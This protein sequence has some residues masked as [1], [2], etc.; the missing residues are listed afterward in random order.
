M[1]RRFVVF[2]AL[3]LCVAVWV[4]DAE[5]AGAWRSEVQTQGVGGAYFL[6]EPGEFW[7]EVEKQDLNR[8]GRETHLRAILFGPEREV[9]AEEFIPD[10]G[11]EKGAGPVQRVRLSTDVTRKGVYGL[12]ITVTEDR[13]GEEFVCGIRTNCPKYLIETS[14]G[15]RDAP[16]EEPTVLASPG[17]SGEICF[18]PRRG[19]FAIE[20]TGLGDATEV[21][22]LTDSEGGVIA[23]IPVVDGAASHTVTESDTRERIPWRLQF[24]SFQGTVQIDGLTRWAQDDDFENLSLWSP[25]AESWFPFSENRW[26]LTPYHRTVYGESGIAR[27]LEFTV[28]NNGLKPQ[29]VS[30]NVEMADGQAMDV[31]VSEKD[32]RLEPKES[33]GVR[34]EFQVPNAP[35]EFHL[36]ATAEDSSFSTYST[37]QVR[38]G[39]APASE[40][41][42]MPLVLRPYAHENAQFGYL[43]EYP[44][45]N[46]PYFDMKNRPAISSDSGVFVLR[47][48]VWKETTQATTAGGEAAPIRPL[49]SKVAFD[50][51]NGYYLIASQGGR[52]TYLHSDDG[53][54][55]FAAYAIPGSGGFDIEQFSGHNQPAG[56]PPFV[57]VTLTERDP[58][59]FWRRVNDLDLF[60]PSKSEDGT[61]V[62]GDPIRVSRLCIGLSAHSGIPSTIV[63]RDDKVH[64]VWAE[65]TE[66]EKDVPGVPT[67]VA[68]YD[69]VAQALSDPVLVGYGPPANDV[70]NTP[71]ITMDSE[72][73]L[74]VLVGTHGR[75]FRYARSLVPNDASGGFTEAEDLGE[76]L[77]QTYIGLVCDKEDTLHAVFRL[78][79][80]DTTY[81]PASSYATLSYMR[82]EKGKPWSAPEPLIIAAF[83]EY[84]VFYHRLTIDRKGSPFLSYDYWSTFWFYRNDHRGDRR[85]LMF[86][87]DRG[88]T[89]KLAEQSNLAQ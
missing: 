14:R 16:H 13:Y 35:G 34:V 71:S 5:E 62:V 19:E 24:P 63:S 61:I 54:K 39:T 53:G 47:D 21:L 72:G 23:E 84:S 40:P 49:T 12:N 38:P 18:Q 33:R 31:S 10:D 45:T 25:N 67:F 42:D 88:A 82:K 89:W 86:T 20:A 1:G 65:A 8:R 46:Q 22:N 51:E 44:L 87:P 64:V 17:E 15:H 77:R 69:R 50:A 29:S 7:V 43:P 74:H 48:G 30:L 3:Y 78:W 32:M 36:R 4:S 26:L 76:D 59:V 6:V 2:A 52:S 81:F 60:V 57:R 11:V 9:I 66:P 85:A 55:R 70:H 58:N 28:H 80:T 68:T 75:T 56:P 41:L 79:R 37:V 27:S 73:Y 83:S